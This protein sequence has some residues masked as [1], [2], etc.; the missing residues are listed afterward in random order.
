ME[1]M[2][3][4]RE[5]AVPPRRLT[6]SDL[7]PTDT[8]VVRDPWSAL[9]ALS[10]DG[11]EDAIDR[12]SYDMYQREWQD[13]EGNLNRSST[14]GIPAEYDVEASTA[15]LLYTLVRWRRPQRVLETGI[16]RGFSTFA[17]LS[18]VKANGAGIVHSC[19]VDPA[20]GEFVTED[21]QSC[22][23]RHVIDGR[24]AEDSFSSVIEEMDSVDFFFHDSNHRKQWM[25][26]EFRTVLPKM[27]RGGIL[28][29]DDVDLNR[30]F[31][32]I[33]PTCST[34]VIVLDARKAS[35]FAGLR[36]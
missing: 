17:L 23:V 8:L 26:F 6:L 35:A 25:E 14:T 34:S 4:V 24:E 29:S 13:V 20:A 30:A 18:A 11:G 28:G 15:Q 7:A 5:Y 1:L 32:S 22:W 27:S 21:L 9:V 16:A 3:R 36:G 12:S 2:R 19:D 10:E 33:L 31:L